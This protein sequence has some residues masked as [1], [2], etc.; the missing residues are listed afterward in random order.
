MA[1]ISTLYDEE[2]KHHITH[3][4]IAPIEGFEPQEPLRK[5][6]TIPES[7]AFILD[8]FLTQEEAKYVNIA[9]NIWQ[10]F[11]IITM[12]Y[13]IPNTISTIYLVYYLTLAKGTIFK[14]LKV[15]ASK[16]L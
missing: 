12:K 5:D 11:Y 4:A 16:V 2:W 10:I 14:K 13:L 15:V 1:M 9:N 3:K 6:L 8:D 7:K